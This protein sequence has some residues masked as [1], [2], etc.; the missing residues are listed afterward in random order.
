MHMYQ[1]L[2]CFPKSGHGCSYMIESLLPFNE[3]CKVVLL[4]IL[5]LSYYFS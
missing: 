1:G 4:A 5:L 3:K 2:A